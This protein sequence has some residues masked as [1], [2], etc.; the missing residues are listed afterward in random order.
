[1]F[2]WSCHFYCWKKMYTFWLIDLYSSN[3]LVLSSTFKVP[4]E[5][6]RIPLIFL[7]ALWLG[8]TRLEQIVMIYLVKFSVSICYGK[9]SPEIIKKEISVFDALFSSPTFRMK[10]YKVSH[11]LSVCFLLILAILWDNIK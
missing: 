8:T 9:R 5:N 7:L 4:L 2:V 6:L 11:C 10:I 1:M 3:V